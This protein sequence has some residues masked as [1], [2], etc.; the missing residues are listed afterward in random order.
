MRGGLRGLLH[1]DG[2]GPG[3]RHGHPPES[4]RLRSGPHPA[5]QV[6]DGMGDGKSPPHQDPHQEV[7][8][9]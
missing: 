4:R 3:C 1:G 8:D 9:R 6:A 5:Q 7:Q 2:G